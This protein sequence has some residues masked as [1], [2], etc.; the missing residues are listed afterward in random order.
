MEDLGISLSRYFCVS[1]GYFFANFF[2]IRSESFFISL[3]SKSKDFVKQS[4]SQ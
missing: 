3:S 2:T 4:A 1:P